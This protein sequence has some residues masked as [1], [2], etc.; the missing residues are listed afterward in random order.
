ML[1]DSF[2]R[3][4]VL[5]FRSGKWTSYSRFAEGN[6]D[7]AATVQNL[8][9]LSD[10]YPRPDEVHLL[11]WELWGF[12]DLNPEKKVEL[13]AAKNREQLSVT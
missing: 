3:V 6:E 7:Q 13:E 1:I 12:Q 5:C 2:R 4:I 8:R 10:A 11:A 9:R